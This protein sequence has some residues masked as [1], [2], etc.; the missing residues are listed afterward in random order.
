MTE[1][2]MRYTWESL[3]WD[4]RSGGLFVSTISLY[5][6]EYL[7][8]EEGWEVEGPARVTLKW[9]P[10]KKHTRLVCKPLPAHEFDIDDPLEYPCASCGALRKSPC[11]GN[12]ER[13][14]FRVF[15]YSGGTL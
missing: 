10:S 11:I 15:S 6:S 12:N 14:T 1:R 8:I 2:T 13:C 4:E 5:P 9:T 3:V 7:R